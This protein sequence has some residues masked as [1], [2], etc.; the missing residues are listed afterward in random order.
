M[1]S[2]RL[3]LP[4][5]FFLVF[6]LANRLSAQQTFQ[7]AYSAGNADAVVADILP[8]SGGYVLAGV[9]G[10]NTPGPNYKPLLMKIGAD[11]SLTWLRYYGPAYQASLDKVIEANDGGLLAVGS[12][13]GFTSQENGQILI[14]KTDSDGV[15]QW[16]KIIPSYISGRRN[17]GDWVQAVPGGYIISGSSAQGDSH[18]V[19]TRIDNLGNT[20]W[21]KRCFYDWGQN[22]RL[23]AF[24]ISGDT[25]FA[26]GIRDSFATFSLF[27]AGSGNPLY[28]RMID[29]PSAEKNALE[30]M[31]PAS[32]GD[33]LLAGPVFPPSSKSVQWVC[34]ISRTG[35]LRWSKVYSNV[36]YGQ[37][38]PL[39]DGNFLLI[40]RRNEPQNANLDPTLV[41]I[42]GNGEVL[43]S[44]QYALAGRDAFYSAI[45]TADGGMLAVG[46]VV[47]PGHSA[48]SI[49]VVKTDANG[50]ITTCCTQP[51]NT[52]ASPFHVDLYDAADMNQ[53]SFDPTWNL[54]I[55]SESASLD[56]LDYC[57][58][59]PG[60]KEI[61]LC[62]GDS[63]VIDGTAYTGQGFVTTTVPGPACD[64]NLVYNIRTGI[65]PTLEETV[66]FCPGDSVILHAVTYTQPGTYMQVVPSATG[67]CD[68]LATYT[69]KHTLASGPTAVSVQCPA[70]MVIQ[71]PYGTPSTPVIF[72]LPTA[73]SDCP[74]PGI[75]LRQTGGLPGGSVFPI[76]DQ[77]LCFQAQ[78]SCGNQAAC[79]FQVRVTADDA[80]PCDIKTSACVVVE[81]LRI[82]GDAQGRRSYHIRVQNNCSQ[83]LSYAAFKLPAGVVAYSPSNNNTYGAPSGR[84]YTVRNP[85]YSPVYSIQF[86]AQGAG[87]KAGESDIFT[88]TLPARSAPDYINSVIKLSGQSFTE[89]H[90]NTFNCPV[91]KEVVSPNQVENRNTNHLAS[92]ASVRLFPNPA[93]KELFI[94]LEN[95]ERRP[96]HIRLFSAQGRLL[97]TRDMESDQLALQLDLPA[98]I[99]FIETVTENGNQ[100]QVRRFVVR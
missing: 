28:H 13:H 12:S 80:A 86:K 65:N 55:P 40:P 10:F 71:V 74:C 53:A 58:P 6:L 43:W 30:A 4:G 72:P 63:I 23:P 67:Q 54:N 42:D 97:L 90:L 85:N 21:S 34:R 3:R 44:Y 1:S 56:I 37:I 75:D 82:T 89:V 78:D 14:V 95:W 18:A 17:G 48:G 22:P 45:E 60:Y 52:K 64:T 68:T 91:E 38:S 46:F 5:L 62:P 9:A 83:A 49:L 84:Q 92:N 11:G 32:N 69:L 24:H 50:L 33:W 59:V 94:E 76:G 31:A 16:Q 73:Q 20:V 27:D 66:H 79:C 57:P 87:I 2:S 70:D 100:R 36:G 98:G 81:L 35:D 51:V 88:Y 41:K 29:G 7:K 26:V 99:Y 61:Y 77:T 8:V 93:E 47:L 96:T 19:L 25:I 39:S 15:L